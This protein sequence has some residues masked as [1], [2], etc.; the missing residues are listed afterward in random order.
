MTT[1]AGVPNVPCGVESHIHSR[2]TKKRKIV[3]NVPCGVERM[4]LLECHGGV[5]EYF[6]FLM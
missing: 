1:L 5:F 4:F 3:P 6:E 2:P